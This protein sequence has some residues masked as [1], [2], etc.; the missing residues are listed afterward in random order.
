MSQQMET[1][2]DHLKKNPSFLQ[3]LTK[4][5]FITNPHKLIL[6]MSPDAE[7]ENYLMSK[8][9]ELLKEKL[10]K[11][12]DSE[13]KVIFKLGQDLQ[14]E[15]QKKD[16]VSVLPTLYLKDISRKLPPTTLQDISLE[17]I[18]IQVNFV[19]FQLVILFGPIFF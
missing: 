11:L 4:K 13:K 17:G 8:E 9:E 7:F 5:Y 6:T 12:N 16:D 1:L 10:E 18:T 14:K 19:I 3:D 2:K 15:Q